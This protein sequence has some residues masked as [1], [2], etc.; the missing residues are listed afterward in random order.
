M[1]TSRSEQLSLADLEGPAELDRRGKPTRCPSCGR[2]FF[3]CQ[4]E[5]TGGWMPI[6]YEPHQNG[7][8]LLV[9]DFGAPDRVLA[10][11]LSKEALMLA[12]GADKQ[13]FISHFATCTNAASYRRPA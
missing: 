1:T 4:S 9:P 10:R 11:V 7:N 8:I 6:D 3:Y 13:L 2:E 12:R 5:A